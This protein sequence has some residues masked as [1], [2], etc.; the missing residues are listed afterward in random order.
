MALWSS[1]GGFECATSGLGDVTASDAEQQGGWVDEPVGCM[2]SAGVRV[3]LGGVPA[4]KLFVQGVAE[5]DFENMQ[6]FVDGAGEVDVPPVE[7]DSLLQGGC[8]ADVGCKTFR[9]D[10]VLEDPFDRCLVR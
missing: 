10:P 3:Q 6:R 5:D 2:K 4:A 1:C 9:A 8:H 7:P